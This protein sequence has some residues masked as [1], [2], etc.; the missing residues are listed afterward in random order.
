MDDIAQILSL[1]SATNIYRIFQESLTNIVKH[2]QATQIFISIQNPDNGVSFSIKDN[3][4]GYN[5]EQVLSGEIAADRMGL[6][7]IEER[8]RI[9]GGSLK[10][11]SQPGKGT[12]ISVFVP[13]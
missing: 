10:I 12:E 6:A 5:L 3:G 2:S 9:L 1:Q 7:A 11:S 4:I 8:V 13:L